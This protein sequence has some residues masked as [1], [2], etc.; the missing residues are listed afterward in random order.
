MSLTEPRRRFQIFISSTFEDLR[1]QREE[2]IQALLRINCIPAGMEMFPAANRTQ[3]ELIERMIDDSDAVVVVVAQRYGSVDDAGVSYTQK[4][5]EYAERTGKPILA[6]PQEL[7]AEETALLDPKLAA[8]RQRISGGIRHVRFWSAVSLLPGY[9]AADL[10]GALNTPPRPEGWVRGGHAV[11]EHLDVL[12]GTVAALMKNFDL[13]GTQVAQI[14]NTVTGMRSQLDV[15]TELLRSERY[16]V[17]AMA[18]YMR[19]QQLKLD[20]SEQNPM[21]GVVADQLLAHPLGT[22]EQLASGHA[23]VPDYQIGQAN[24]LLI[25]A[26]HKRFDAVTHDD[27]MFWQ[28]KANIDSKYRHAVYDAIHRPSE[29]ILAT[30]IF[31]PKQ[32]LADRANEIAAVLGEQMSHQLA[33][34]VVIH[35]DVVADVEPNARLDFALFDWGKAVSY[36]RHNR[37]FDVTFRRSGHT[38]NDSEIDRQ[39][40]TYEMLLSRCWIATKRFSET[41][42]SA[43]DEAAVLLRASSRIRALK[44]IKYE[45]A[46]R[47]FPIII[48]TDNDIR[49]SLSELL[50]LHDRVN[51]D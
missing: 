17:K 4:E 31:V 45:H 44:R 24:D 2:I 33:I 28:S 23:S 48:D 39:L 7:G 51:A 13:Q 35:E 37:R 43:G 22:L 49:S 47:L 5:F 8:F 19:V 18:N 38:E 40:R 3:W 1:E 41:H 16:G 32:T 34:A 30:R 36:F 27:L 26:I 11:S 29:P 14:A 25:G 20:L 46:S 21:F 15:V 10:V 6:F 50:T 9:I 42:I 12:R